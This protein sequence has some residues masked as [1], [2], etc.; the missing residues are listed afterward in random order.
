MYTC[1]YCIKHSDFVMVKSSSRRGTELCNLSI[2][3]SLYQ[4]CVYCDVPSHC[5]MTFIYLFILDYWES[6]CCLLQIVYIYVSCLLYIICHKRTPFILEITW[7]NAQFF[8]SLC[9]NAIIMNYYNLS[10]FGG[11]I[12]KTECVPSL[13]WMFTK[14]ECRVFLTQSPWQLGA[15][16]PR[17]QSYR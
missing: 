1:R 5:L 10:T 16:L 17:T 8:C 4:M 3:Y 11:V 13:L 6:T 9:G 2:A 15:G 14:T 7:P 12:D